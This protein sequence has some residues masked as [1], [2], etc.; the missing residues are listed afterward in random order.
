M[1]AKDGSKK[2]VELS[3]SL[4]RDSDG[5][6][7]GFRGVARDITERK[8]SEEQAKLHQQQL[9][10]ASK[11]VALGT[12][13]S[14]VAHEIN[15]PNNF[16]MLNS[17]ILKEAWEN[18]MPILE[19]YYEENGDFIMGGMK[20]SEMRDNIP[21]LFSGISD[22]SKRIKRIVDDLKNYVRND[23][24][25]LT[26]PI[27]I[28][29]VIKSAVSLLTNMIKNTTHNFSIEKGND[30]P[31]LKGNFQRLEQVMINLIQNACQALPDNN[32]G[33]YISTAY[34]QNNSNIVVTIRDEG[35]GM[36]PETVE[37]IMDPFFTTKHDAGGIGLGLSISSRIVEEHGGTLRF[38]SEPGA[39]TTA[40][41]TLPIEREKQTLEGN[42][43]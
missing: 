8:K 5:Q 24:A 32:R 34:D 31:V 30:L 41:I 39:G 19:K 21:A 18:A 13:V 23:S 38:S 40:T 20:F 9:M 7:M 16:I 14:G 11:M 28:N 22:G 43:E 33:I 15:N 4:M 27:D 2:F 36:P 1:I 25:D 42:P 12:L 6:P 10:Q 17:P 37:H 29:A 3:V 26:Q 35:V